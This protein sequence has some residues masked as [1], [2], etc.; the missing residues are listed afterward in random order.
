M[1]SLKAPTIFVI[2]AVLFTALAISG[3]ASPTPTATP[4]AA[5]SA[6]PLPSPSAGPAAL[7]ITGMVNTPLS[8]AVSDLDGYTQHFA[9]WQNNAGDSSYSGTGPLVL[10]C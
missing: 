7:S 10:I 6:T 2:L 4:T 8:L 5:P 9:L 1:R 3:C